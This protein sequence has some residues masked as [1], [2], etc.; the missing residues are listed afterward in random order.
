MPVEFKWDISTFTAAKIIN[1]CQYKVWPMLLAHVFLS[2]LLEV[3][4]ICLTGKTFG[5]T[6]INPNLSCKPFLL[7]VKNLFNA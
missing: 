5:E 6:G 3:A 2:V 7:E 1:E 4:F